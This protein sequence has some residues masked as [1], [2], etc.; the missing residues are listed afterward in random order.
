MQIYDI[1]SI[2]EVLHVLLLVTGFFCK[3]DI[4]FCTLVNMNMWILNEFIFISKTS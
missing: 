1:Y 3:S 2:E 4:N